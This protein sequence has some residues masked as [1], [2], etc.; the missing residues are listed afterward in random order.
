ME[1]IHLAKK[2]VALHQPDYQNKVELD[3]VVKRMKKLPPLV[4]AGEVRDLK[5]R[6]M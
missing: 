3:K 2:K 5:K 1:P 4:F 6:I